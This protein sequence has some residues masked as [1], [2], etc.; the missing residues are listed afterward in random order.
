MALGYP[1]SLSCAFARIGFEP[2][3]RLAS[4]A[5]SEQRK[6]ALQLL[7]KEQGG[8]KDSRPPRPSLGR[9]D[10]QISVALKLPHP[11]LRAAET[12]RGPDTPKYTCDGPSMEGPPGEAT[13]EQSR[14]L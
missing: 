1:A 9:T 11:Q 2:K 14:G 7:E 12:K 13:V 8:P 6:R 5:L 4:P 3:A 10:T